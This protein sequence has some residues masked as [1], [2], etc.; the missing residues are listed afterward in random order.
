[1]SELVL[2]IQ[3]LDNPHVDC[4]YADGNRM[5]LDDYISVINTPENSPATSA[6]SILG[7]VYP[8]AAF[9]EAFAPQDDQ[10]KPKATAKT[11]ATLGFA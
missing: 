6:A 4:C 3:H 11:T 1:M 8:E 2:H 10:S 7:T 5:R 9:L